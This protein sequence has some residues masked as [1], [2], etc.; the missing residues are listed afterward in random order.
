MAGGTDVIGQ[1][2]TA[3]GDVSG[4]EDVAVAGAQRGDGGVARHLGQVTVEQGLTLV[5]FTA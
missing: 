5:H 3:S 4:D 1:A 2:P